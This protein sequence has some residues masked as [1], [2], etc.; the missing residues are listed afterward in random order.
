MGHSFGGV[1]AQEYALTHP[2][3][4]ELLIVLDGILNA[5]MTLRAVVAASEK[6]AIAENNTQVL[7]IV[8]KSKKGEK[9]SFE[10]ISILFRERRPYWYHFRDE[11]KMTYGPNVTPL[12][13]NDQN[14]NDAIDVIKIFFDSGFM[15]TYSF[16]EGAHHLEVPT[17]LIYGKNDGITK[18][19]QAQKVSPMLPHGKLILIPEC[20]HFPHIE[21]PLELKKAVLALMK[22]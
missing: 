5:K 6:Y 18:P 15:D 20:G 12:G 3:Q 2:D 19:S 4:V 13:Y 7:G 16:F 21:K 1:I 22:Q 14:M 8:E 10:E 11:S 9:L 17:V